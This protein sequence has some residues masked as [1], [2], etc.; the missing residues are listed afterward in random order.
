MRV[1]DILRLGGMVV[2]GK[3][4]VEVR[5]VVLEEV[6]KRVVKGWERETRKTKTER[7]RVFD[8]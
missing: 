8:M 1:S 2:N 3:G 5:V 7:M 6:E 4:E